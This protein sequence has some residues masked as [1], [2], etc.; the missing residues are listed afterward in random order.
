M[1]RQERRGFVSK[2]WKNVRCDFFQY[3]FLPHWTI[4]VKYTICFITI[5]HVQFIDILK[6][7]K[8]FSWLN[9]LSMWLDTKESFW[10]MI[11]QNRDQFWLS[12]FFLIFFFIVF[13][14]NT[15]H[16]FCCRLCLAE[17]CCHLMH[18]TINYKRCQNRQFKCYDNYVFKY[19]NKLKICR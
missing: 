11:L 8:H 16:R 14:N 3:K 12:I 2:E 4:N 6:L 17:M 1:S 9:I 18:N 7:L 15:T 10:N 19:Q 13:N 5:Y